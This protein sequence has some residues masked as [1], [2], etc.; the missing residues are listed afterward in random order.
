MIA[1]NEGKATEWDPEVPGC[2]GMK[3]ALFAVHP[4]DERRST[5]TTTV[6][7]PTRVTK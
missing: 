4:L 2:F 3:D 6:A 7:P 1:S 5:R